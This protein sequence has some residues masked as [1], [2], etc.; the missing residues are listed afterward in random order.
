MKK[1]LSTLTLMVIN[2]V[3]AL[4]QSQPELNTAAYKDFLKADKE[5]NSVYNKILKEYK[6]DTV[7]TKN[8]KQA[9]KLW[10]KLRAAEME[11]K[12]PDATHRPY[13]SVL[14]MC[15]SMYLTELTKERTTHLRIWIEGIEE[16]DVCSGSVEI[17]S[18]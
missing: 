13:G 17:K 3:F 5:L 10:L 12:Y 11:V 16:G 18:Q 6:A 9:Q 2:F 14:P 4:S 1:S 7:F 15:W 8:L